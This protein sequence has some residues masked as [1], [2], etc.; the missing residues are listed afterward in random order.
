MSVV[1]VAAVGRTVTAVPVLAAVSMKAVVQMGTSGTDGVDSGSPVAVGS[2][3][4][5]SRTSS[6][7]RAGKVVVVPGAVVSV[8]AVVPV[9]AVVPM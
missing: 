5:G 2:S 4:R 1:P 3:R 9:V 8:F 6:P 7:R